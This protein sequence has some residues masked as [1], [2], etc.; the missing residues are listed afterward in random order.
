[1][2]WYARTHIITQE[3]AGDERKSPEKSENKYKRL[4]A[5]SDSDDEVTCMLARVA[6]CDVGVYLGCGSRSLSHTIACF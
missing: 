4:L 6:P 3:G 2:N 5:E 1:M